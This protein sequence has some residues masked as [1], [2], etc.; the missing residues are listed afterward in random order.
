MPASRQKGFTQIPNDILEK[1]YS[2][3]FTAKQ[4][5][6]IL[7]VLRY[8]T[9]FHKKTALIPQNVYF[10][11]CGISNKEMKNDDGPINVL[12]EAN[13]LERFSHGQDGI[14]YRVNPNTKEWKFSPA[15]QA[16]YVRN[17]K[18]SQEQRRQRL[19]RYQSEL[20][21]KAAKKRRPEKPP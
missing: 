2:S 7:L 8:S 11:I 5:R 13:V 12:Q 16:R 15:I 3:Q 6:A 9:G 10:E 19:E 14:E 18:E 4:L 1:I 17:G 20:K 21:S